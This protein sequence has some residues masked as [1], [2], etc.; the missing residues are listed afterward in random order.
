M[1]FG[2]LGVFPKIRGQLVSI[3]RNVFV[4]VIWL[5]FFHKFLDKHMNCTHPKRNGL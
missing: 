1:F 2:Y 5:V 3:N 4:W